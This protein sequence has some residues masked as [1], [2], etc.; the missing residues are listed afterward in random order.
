MAIRLFAFGD[1]YPEGS[2]E[3]FSKLLGLFQEFVG[4]T[5]EGPLYV[6]VVVAALMLGLSDHLKE[7][8]DDPST[9]EP[10]MQL[11]FDDAIEDQLNKQ[12]AA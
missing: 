2:W 1:E 7:L 8:A 10:L 4:K 12:K 11:K 9:I 6:Y 5:I 3:N